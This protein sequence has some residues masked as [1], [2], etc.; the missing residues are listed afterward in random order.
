MAFIEEIAIMKNSGLISAEV[1]FYMFGEDAIASKKSPE[2]RS[3]FAP[4]GKAF[5]WSAYEVFC[6]EMDDLD[7]LYQT[8]TFN[9]KKLRF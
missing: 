2:F 5:T 9:P 4:W 6:D 1:A 7:K 3:G 8:K